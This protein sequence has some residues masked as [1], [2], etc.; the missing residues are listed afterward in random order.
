MLDMKFFEDQWKG[1]DFTAKLIF[2]FS[3]TPILKIINKTSQ[4]LKLACNIGTALSI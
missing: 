2:Q 4:D 1:E 3:S